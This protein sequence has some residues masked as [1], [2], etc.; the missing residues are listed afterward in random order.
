[1]SDPT[2]DSADPLIRRHEK[3]RTDRIAARLGK[4]I[5]LVSEARRHERPWLRWLALRTG[6]ASQAL[7]NA[8]RL[9]GTNDYLR[10]PEASLVGV[11]DGQLG[12][13]STWFM[14]AR[15]GATE[16]V[17][18]GGTAG[19]NRFR[20]RVMATG[21][22]R[23]DMLTSGAANVYVWDVGG[24]GVIS[25]TD[26]WHHFGFSFDATTL[27]T[28]TVKS[29]LD[30]VSRYNQL[31]A[32]ATPADVDF[33]RDW[34]I[35]ALADGAGKA[36]ISLAETYFDDSFLDLDTAA[37]LEKFRSSDGKAVDLGAD[38][39]TPTGAQPL[40]CLNKTVANWHQN[41]GSAGDY[42]LNG[43]LESV[44]GPERA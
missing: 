22:I 35:G 39:S 30:A 32:G 16:T 3:W 10:I 41:A 42:T 44:T 21:R 27:P 17:W 37:N 31:G 43:A 23:V 33:T 14:L 7:V 24:A 25:D 6:G 40:M 20:V 34:T 5:F 8:V 15:T 1:M 38:G 26:T 4:T 18:N 36:D 19:S 11:S 29:Y 28:V 13:F 9:D 12:L 2:I